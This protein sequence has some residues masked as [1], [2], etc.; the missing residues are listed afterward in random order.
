MNGIRPRFRLAVIVSVALSV[1]GCQSGSH[2][3][4]P[5]PAASTE[6]HEV[7]RWD[8]PPPAY[9]G[10]PAADSSGVAF[11]SALSRLILLDTDGHVT[12][13]A[14]KL[15]LRDVAPL[16]TPDLVVAAT[17]SGMAAFD[18]TTGAVAWSSDFGQRA[19]T[20]VS[21]GDVLVTSTWDGSIVG[22]D[23]TTGARKWQ[24]ALPGPAF[25]PA[26]S[27]GGL[28][29][30]TWVADDHS[31]AGAV[32]V[33]AATGQQRWSV[34]LP[35][36]GVSAPG[37]GSGE[38]ARV[39]VV[40]GDVA[41]HALDLETGAELW[42][43]GLEGAGSP[44]VRPLPVA[45][46]D[47]LV[48]HRLGGMAILD[49]DGKIHWQVSSGGAA[50]RGAPAGPGPGGR[51]ALPLDDGRLLLAGPGAPTTVLD[52][53]GRVSGVAM[54]P[55]AVLVVGTREASVNGVNASSGW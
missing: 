21:A 5:A 13:I 44:E 34:P 28:A 38:P 48:A 8:A 26:A 23:E 31:Q 29:V 53:P 18:R 35:T 27:E 30:T 9:V 33:D 49:S 52:P 22:L 45:G 54:G 20:P 36:G 17:E 3:A 32:A 42:R 15:H 7:W 37:I 47:V 50:V 2:R 4:S 1:A 25:G 14:E 55:A 16:L 39:V 19:N 10:M 40:A 46:G 41:A 43:T 24:S 6:V 11:T 12:W 51:F